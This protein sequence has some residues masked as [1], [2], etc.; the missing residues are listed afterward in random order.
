M[1]T[2]K[3]SRGPRKSKSCKTAR[4]ASVERHVREN[5]FDHLTQEQVGR[6]FGFGE[7]AMRALARIPGFPIVAKKINPEHFKRWLWEHHREI[8]ATKLVPKK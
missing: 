6:L 2:H 5:V 7:E 4:K 3:L 8:S 1:R